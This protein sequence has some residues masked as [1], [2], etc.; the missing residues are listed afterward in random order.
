M[1]VHLTL[2]V[3]ILLLAGGVNA[4]EPN[5]G[6]KGGLNLYNIENENDVKYDRNIGYHIGM[7][8]HIHLASKFGIQPE[9]LYSAQGAKF[10]SALGEV[11]LKLAYVNVPVM[12]QYMFDNGFRFEL[13][14][15]IGFLAKAN[16]ELNSS[17]TDIKDDLNGIDIA[18]GVGLGYINLPT[19][20]GVDARYNYGLTNINENGNSS[21]YNRGFQFGVFYQF[22]HQ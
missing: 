18:V 22:Q 9:L 21:S 19:G 17:E 10:D 5:F 4:Q 15:Q 16:S 2:I 3:A 12:V 6:I 11:T 14:P 20:F 8:L 7:L 13:G 1:K